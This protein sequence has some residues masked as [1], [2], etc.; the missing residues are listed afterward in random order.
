[1]NEFESDNVFARAEEKG[2]LIINGWTVAIHKDAAK[3]YAQN[4]PA[5]QSPS[6]GFM[7]VQGKVVLTHIDCKLTLTKE[8]AVAVIDL[9]NGAY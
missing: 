6:E 5:N 3:K 4:Y 8:E 9:I 1:M 7:D 2:I